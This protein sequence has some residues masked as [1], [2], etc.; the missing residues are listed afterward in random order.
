[1]I[2]TIAKFFVLG[3]IV[4]VFNSSTTKAC[5]CSAQ[6][7]LSIMNLND[8]ELIFTATLLEYRVGMGAGSLVFKPKHIY[9]GTLEETI[10]IY[11]KPKN[12]H[13]L[14]NKSVQ[15][16]EQK[17][18]IVFARKKVVAERKYYRLM[19]SEGSSY[20]A[21][22][23]PIEKD[24]KKDAYLDFLSTMGRQADGYQKIYNEQNI[25]IAEGKYENNRPIKEW[26]YYQTDGRPFISGGYKD[27][28]KFGEWLKYTSSS[29]GS[30]V[31]IQKKY[32]DQGEL[33]EIHDLR[34]SGAVSF[35][36]F[37]SDTTEIRH[38]LFEDGTLNSVTYR[39]KEDNSMNTTSYY[40]SGI[41]REEK[42]FEEDKLIYKYIYNENGQ[43]VDEWVRKD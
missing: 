32:Y 42:Y 28:K 5:S 31:V 12:G 3:S 17:D 36:K 11:F 16:Q 26:K 9:K 10:T 34:Y 14:F 1:M 27:G 15:F 6:S 33:K 22:T 23:R 24:A 2:Q 37:L 35:K 19:D 41:I 7:N 38:Y 21:L 18:W 29:K 20:C 25:L 8:S 4:F 40:K 43:K 30:A 39:N 13:T